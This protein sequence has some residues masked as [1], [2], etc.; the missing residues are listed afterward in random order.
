MI[1]L[2]LGEQKSYPIEEQIILRVPP[3]LQ[4]IAKKISNSEE[5]EDFTIKFTGSRNAI[6]Q[7]AGVDYNAVLVDLP[8][9]IE[10]QKTMDKKQFYK[11]CDISQ[12][13]VVLDENQEKM[14]I[15]DDFQYAHG[16]T[17]PMQ[18][19]RQRRFRKRATKTVKCMLKL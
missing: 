6:V 5:V 1:T 17:K 12:M 3:K 19:V 8:C 4:E 9:L 15:L 2:K 18:R 14:G 10:S 16:L 13:L 7:V 11:I